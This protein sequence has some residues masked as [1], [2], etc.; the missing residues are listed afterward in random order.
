MVPIVVKTTTVTV[1]ITVTTEVIVT[2]VVEMP[3]FIVLTMIEVTMF[4]AFV[5]FVWSSRFH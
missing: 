3:T 4:M 5:M 1:V 2:L